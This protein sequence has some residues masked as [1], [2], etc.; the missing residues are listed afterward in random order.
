MPGP[1]RSSAD[2]SSAVG[3]ATPPQFS[4]SLVR[5]LLLFRALEFEPPAGIEAGRETFDKNE[6]EYMA[7]G[8]S[9]GRGRGRGCTTS[10]DFDDRDPFD[11]KRGT[12]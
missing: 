8:L 10:T 11:T 2:S 6:D 12:G 7:R 3:T 9:A 5:N 4:S 1:T